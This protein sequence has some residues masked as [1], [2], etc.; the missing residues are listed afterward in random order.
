M[1]RARRGGHPDPDV[2]ECTAIGPLQGGEEQRV[3]LLIQPAK[4]R[5][6]QSDEGSRAIFARTI[7]FFE[8]L[9]KKRVLE[10][11]TRKAWY[12]EFVEFIGPERPIAEITGELLS[13]YRRHLLDRTK[14]GGG[15]KFNQIDNLDDD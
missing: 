10:D 4:Y 7:E 15:E 3:N 12:A 8:G 14:K 9:G 1:S 13:Q 5:S 11:F 6:L 2:V